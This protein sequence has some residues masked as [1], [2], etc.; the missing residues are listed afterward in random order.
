MILASDV[1]T[2]I[3]AHLDDDNSGRYTE[4]DDFAPIVNSTIRYLIAIFNVAFEQKKAAPE[5]LRELVRVAILP[6]TGAGNIKKANITAGGLNI[7]TIFG[8]EPDP[9][10]NSYT[11]PAPGTTA[12]PEVFVETRN[13]LAD[14]LTLEQWN[15][16]DEDPFSAGTLQSI[17]GTFVR[18]AYLGPGRYFGAAEDYILIKPASVFTDD[19]VGIWYLINPTKVT[20]GVSQIAFPESMF[21]FVVDKSLNYLSRQQGP[22]SKLGPITKQEVEQLV[23]LIN[24]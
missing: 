7:W 10:I 14:R 16:S 5:S 12:A 19:F 9:S 3:R 1:F 22:D 17:P 23:S 13:K 15:E 20:S 11:T 2:A 4:V 8:V 18:A 24:S 21:N 6:V